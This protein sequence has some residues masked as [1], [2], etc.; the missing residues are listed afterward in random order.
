MVEDPHFGGGRSIAQRTV[1]C[2]QIVFPPIVF[3]QDSCLQNRVE[4]LSVEQLVPQ[5]SV[6]LFDGITPLGPLFPLHKE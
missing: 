3:R 4:D 1:W 2:D 6:E 5:F